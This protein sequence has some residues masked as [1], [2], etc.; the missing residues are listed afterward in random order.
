[1]RRF[2]SLVFAA[3]LLAF[4][5]A[6]PAA[7]G[8]S[9]MRT[10]DA[11][12][13]HAREKGLPVMVD[14][15]AR[16][17][18][19]CVRMD[20]LVFAD[21]NLV[22]VSKRFVMIRID[23]EQ[24][25]LAEPISRFKVLALPTRLFLDPWENVLMRQEGYAAA[26]DLSGV[27]VHMPVSFET[28]SRHFETLS[29]RPKDAGALLEIGRF[30]ASAGLVVPAR[31]F[32][33]RAQNASRGG[34][35]RPMRDESIIALGRL[36]LR[37]G[38]SREAARL[39]EEGCRGC[40]PA[41]KPRML[42]G[43]ALAQENSNAP[44]D[45]LDAYRRLAKDFP[46]SPEAR[47]AM[48]ALARLYSA[49]PPAGF[50]PIDPGLLRSLSPEDS[51]KPL[52][53][54]LAPPAR[55]RTPEER[56]RTV[57]PIVD[58]TLDGLRARF[59]DILDRLEP[60]RDDEAALP[61]IL[62]AAG[63][64]VERYFRDFPNVVAREEV[65]HQIDTGRNR[66]TSNREYSYL[67]FVDSGGP[68]LRWTEDRAD[69]HGHPAPDRTGADG[70]AKGTFF[71]TR[72]YAGANAYFHPLHQSGAR[73]RLLGFDRAGAGARLIAFAQVPETATL[74]T[75][76]SMSGFEGSLL[77]QGL[78]WVD[79]QSYEIQ[80]MRIELLAPRDDI[81]L[82]GHSTEIR[83]AAVPLPGAA[84][85]FWLPREVAV[86][87][88]WKGNL[89]RNRHRYSDYRLFSVQSIEGDKQI[90]RP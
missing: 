74:V 40:V 73:F 4:A 28:V 43:L 53:P 78:A 77:V 72:G 88:D 14:F 21:P 41:N 55:P 33:T 59:P 2:P 16:Y 7:D 82:N 79:L 30:Y 44:Q 36:A 90:R 69:P 8:I 5:S 20:S 50:T 89:F 63:E 81:F 65:R 83:F 46:K 56:Y 86:S 13:K 35:Q 39:F 22:E 62:K 15:W 76:F 64:R 12:M 54:P 66:Q 71:I 48:A 70:D 51:G 75:T 17:C 84:Q 27:M 49:K 87:V 6:S 47:D 1:M 80:R 58:F 52:P 68:G 60:S 19:P 25:V 26:R 18:G 11:G 32:L 24:D 9:W 38:D 61:A 3:H 85:P 57:I 37:A 67:M 29:A 23:V 42:L 34:E 31:D 45:A 10:F